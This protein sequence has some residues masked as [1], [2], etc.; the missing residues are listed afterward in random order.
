ML[1]NIAATLS[2]ACFLPASA[3][4]YVVPVRGVADF[5]ASLPKDATYVSFSAAAVYKCDSDIVLPDVQ[6]LVIDGKGCKLVLGPSSNGF[7]CRIANQ[8]E[9]AKRTGQ[10]YAIRDFASIEGGRKA[11]DLQATL[12]SVVENCRL[13][14]QTEAAVDLRFAL[15]TAVRNVIVT[16]P[17]K[18]GFVVRTGD[19]PGATW[20]NS[21]SNHTVL[22]QC[23]VYATASTTQAFSVINC[24]GVRITD[25]ISEGGPCDHDLFLSATT[26]GNEDLPAKNTVVKQFTLSNFHVEHAVRKASIHVNMPSKCSVELS[27]VYW[28]GPQKAPVIYY[29]GGQLNLMGIGWFTEDMRIGTRVSAPRI[30]IDRCHSA[31]S[32]GDGVTNG[33]K[34]A[35]VLHLIDPLPG[36]TGLG[37]TYVK[38]ARSAR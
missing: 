31:L 19:W 21:Q 18:R 28:N 1:R 14:G 9:A 25:C 4:E 20:S 13:V 11:I 22:E 2:C 15:M 6:F 29:V 3:T 27:Q 35:R 7:T 24:N 5:F 23:R 10:R 37:L 36:H 8:Q 32:T 30:T 34:R 33:G 17:G 16:N 12:G 38:V 26:D